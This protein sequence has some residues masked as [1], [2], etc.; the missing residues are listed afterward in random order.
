MVSATA[1]V[2]SS[3]AHPLSPAVTQHF[4]VCLTLSM[5]SSAGP[6]H[7]VLQAQ[8]GAETSAACMTPP[9]S[10]AWLCAY[11]L[12]CAS[13][14]ETRLK[15]QR[16]NGKV[17][18]GA[19]ASWRQASHSYEPAHVCSHLEWHSP[20]LGRCPTAFTSYISLSNHTCITINTLTSAFHHHPGSAWE[21]AVLCS[22]PASGD[23]EAEQ[24]ER[25][26]H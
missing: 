3:K 10:F 2:G 16:K 25:T 1:Q 4:L 13:V 14:P 18:L 21:G 26:K 5:L 8:E 7:A 12:R 24:D 6:T 22:G 19:G 15:R 23:T 11:I 20:I 9:N 17:L